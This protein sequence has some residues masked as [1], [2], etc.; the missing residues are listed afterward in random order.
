[1]QHAW[2]HWQNSRVPTVVQ[3]AWRG[4]ITSWEIM[5]TWTEARNKPILSPLGNILVQSPNWGWLK[6]KVSPDRSPPTLDPLHKSII[7]CDHLCLIRN[8][9]V[10]S[11]TSFSQQ[12]PRRGSR[13]GSREPNGR[14]G[15]R[16]EGLQIRNRFAPTTS[17]TMRRHPN[18]GGSTSSLRRGK[19]SQEEPTFKTT[20][21]I[22]HWSINVFHQQNICL[23]QVVIVDDSWFH[24]ISSGMIWLHVYL[25][26]GI[27]FILFI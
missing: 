16:W 6:T 18:S 26:P 15:R 8:Y 17:P 9:T 27:S 24:K 11:C 2:K 19:L 10:L 14:S 3:E 22:T 7:P 23:P 5:K 1:M 25:F 13:W 4:L 21:A 20:N 12:P